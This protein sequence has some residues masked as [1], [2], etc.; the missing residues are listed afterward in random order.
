MREPAKKTLQEETMESDDSVKRYLQEIQI[1]LRLSCI[2]T[3]GWPVVLSLWYMFEEGYLY[4]ATP[5][6]AKV[7]SYLKQNPRCAF[8]IASD[9]PP[10]CGVRG[11]ALATI[12]QERG[13]AILERLL[14]RY[15]GSTENALAQQLLNRSETEVAILLAPK[16]Y[17]TWNFTD[18]MANS[19]PGATPKLC[20]G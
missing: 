4:C 16:Q 6:N 9:Q 18:R 20:P 10:Y 7:V 1:P 2:S 13:L 11:R 19:I 17:Y 15:L 8:E 12:D 3:S 14:E 5:Q